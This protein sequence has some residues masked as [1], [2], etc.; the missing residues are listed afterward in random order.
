MRERL[1][2]QAATTGGTGLATAVGG[3][4]KA[5]RLIDL[6]AT[7]VTVLAPPVASAGPIIRCY[8]WLTGEMWGS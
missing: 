3:S 7:G 8:R 2:A 6:L 1:S 5:G 4:H